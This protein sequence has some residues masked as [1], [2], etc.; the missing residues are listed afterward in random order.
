MIP[1]GAHYPRRRLLSFCHPSP[2][3]PQP[4]ISSSL[5][6]LSTEFASR[7]PRSL[8]HPPSSDLEVTTSDSRFHCG[9]LLPALSFLY[10]DIAEPPFF[11]HLVPCSLGLLKPVSTSPSIRELLALTNHH[12]EILQVLLPSRREERWQRE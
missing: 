4:Y 10:A 12:H 5:P 1:T 7:V 2:Q 6:P 8:C 3:R 11:L 9:C